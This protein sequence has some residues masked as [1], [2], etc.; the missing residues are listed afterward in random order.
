MSQGPTMK[1]GAVLVLVSIRD[2]SAQVY[3]HPFPAPSAGAAIRSFGDEINREGSEM[4]KHPED[5]ELYELG[6]FDEFDASFVINAKP[7]MI[8]RGLDQVVRPG[9]DRLQ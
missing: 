2:I 5:Y 8:A 6:L 4:G 7:R 1:I 3:R 9:H